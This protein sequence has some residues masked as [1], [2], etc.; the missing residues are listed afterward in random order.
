MPKATSRKTLVV[1]T[2]APRSDA[3]TPRTAS[4]TIAGNV[5]ATPAPKTAVATHRPS[6]VGARPAM[7]MPVALSTSAVPDRRA[8]PKRSGH[9]APTM[10]SPTTTSANSAR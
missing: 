2:T 5:N 7:V 9:R 1:P 3:G 10:R 8:A 6:S 4:E